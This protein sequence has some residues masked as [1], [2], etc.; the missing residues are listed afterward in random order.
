MSS[1]HGFMQRWNWWKESEPVSFSNFERYFY[2]YLEN[3]IDVKSPENIEGIESLKQETRKKLVEEIF[4]GFPQFQAKWEKVGQLDRDGYVIEKW[5]IETQPGFFVPANIYHPDTVLQKRPGILFTPGHTP[6]GKAFCEYQTAVLSFVSQGYVVLNYDPLGQGERGMYGSILSG[7]HHDVSSYQCIMAGEHSGKYFTWDAMKCIDLLLSRTDVDHARIG[8]TGCSGGG[9][10]TI[11]VTALD[12]RIACSVC[13]VAAVPTNF[14]A[15]NLPGCSHH[16]E[17]N[18]PA[19]CTE[20]G[21]SLEK[22]GMCIAPRPFLILGGTYD[23]SFPPV[24][25]NEYYDWLRAVYDVYEK[26]EKLK[27][28]LLEADH[29]Y[30]GVFQN[31]ACLWFNKWFG[32]DEQCSETIRPRVE[33]EASLE[34][35][36]AIYSSGIKINS[37]SGLNYLN[38]NN[39]NKAT[40]LDNSETPEMVALALKNEIT[41]LLGIN[42]WKEEKYGF[43][44]LPFWPIYEGDWYIRRCSIFDCNSRHL[45]MDA[46]LLRKYPF[47]PIKKIVLVMNFDGENILPD[48][49]ERI[50]TA[51]DHGTAVLLPN[52]IANN[53]FLFPFMAGRSALGVKIVM[54]EKLIEYVKKGMGCE[55]ASIE[56]I[57]YNSEGIH[58]LIYS[59]LNSLNIGTIKL[60]NSLE[61]FDQILGNTI[62]FEET[63]NKNYY[64]YDRYIE[65]IHGIA[66]K[67]SPEKL[68]AAQTGRTIKIYNSERRLR[69]KGVRE[70][71]LLYAEK[72]NLQVSF[73]DIFDMQDEL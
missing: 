45:A 20:N 35:L 34:C 54:L 71:L 10:H 43:E 38:W 12:T 24:A 67:I 62:L 60:I 36:D 25:M 14:I 21:V 50:S 47:L 53:G 8:M 44:S 6:Y 68:I 33:S 15:T 27:Y 2:T 9:S 26:Q 58:V 18:Y 39:M 1:I 70:R 29:G 66:V 65:Y 42:E 56:I 72:Y 64:I 37:V 19:M 63:L 52:Q 7:N 41:T 3:G 48:I 23:H 40:K 16:M 22:L 11:Y 17:D 46:A 51:L 57:A 28:R 4:N 13:V 59:L 61:S 49:M 32:K 69:N 55:N 30:S 73:V 31:E 5:I